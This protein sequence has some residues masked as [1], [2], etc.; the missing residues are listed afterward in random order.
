MLKFGGTENLLDVLMKYSTFINCRLANE[1]N[2]D[3]IAHKAVPSELSKLLKSQIFSY[4]IPSNAK[5]RRRQLNN[6][7]T[8]YVGLQRISKYKRPLLPI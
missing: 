8:S 4:L 7:I 3:E 2:K 5:T 6:K 1:L